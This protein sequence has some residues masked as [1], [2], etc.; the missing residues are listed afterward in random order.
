MNRKAAWLALSLVAT[1]PATAGAQSD[2]RRGA[3]A[4]DAPAD[5]RYCL[6]V[7]PITGS[8][9]ETV[10]CRTRE[11]WSEQGV[12]LDQEWRREGVRVITSSEHNA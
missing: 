8:R 6:R 4:P 9:I 7:E 5:A 3:A 2:A 12:D 1:I 10:Q 11:E